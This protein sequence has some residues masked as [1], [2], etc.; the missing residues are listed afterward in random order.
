M[1]KRLVKSNNRMVSGVC[2]GIAEYFG[3][4]PT[5]VRIALVLFCALGG[6]GFLAYVLAAIIMPNA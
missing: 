5:I 2:A 1:N 3:I 6:S 4:D